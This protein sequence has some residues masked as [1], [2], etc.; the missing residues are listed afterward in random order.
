MG[1]I[2][3]VKYHETHHLIQ[4]LPILF[5]ENWEEVTED[6]FKSEV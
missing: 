2:P 3:I 5:V 4:D 6:F 1:S